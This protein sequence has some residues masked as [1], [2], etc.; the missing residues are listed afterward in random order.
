MKSNFVMIPGGWH[1]GWAWAPV[2]RR[3]RGAGHRAVTLTMPGLA[4][5]D[6]AAGW[7]LRDAVAHIVGEVERR[8]LTGITLVAHSW[9][10]FPTTGAAQQL[11]GR[12]SKIVYYNAFVPEP[13]RSTLGEF[14]PELAT[15]IRSAIASTPDHV[16]IPSLDIVRQALLPDEPEAAQ[17]LLLELMAPHPG[18]YG[19]DALDEPA[20]TDLGVPLAYILSEEDRG[21][22]RPNAGA[23]Y[24]AR[25]GV[26]PVMVPGSHES[27]LTHPDEVAAAVMSV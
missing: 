3:L 16:W 14:P 26:T 21:L 27:L 10:G 23:E 25:L 12:L 8:D 1:G 9:G 4:D 7:R 13:G 22:L 2:A 20:V 11:A 18:E 24:A 15:E 5:G 6:D 19:E 17:R